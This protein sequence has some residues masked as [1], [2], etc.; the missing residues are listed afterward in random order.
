[1]GEIE[2]LAAKPTSH[3]AEALFVPECAGTELNRQSPEG[4]LVYSQRG[5]PMPNRRKLPFASSTDGSRTHRHSRR[6]ELRRFAGL[7]TVL[8]CPASPM[9]F[10]PTISCVTGRRALRAAPRGRIVMS[11]AQVGLEPTASLVLSQG[12]LPIAYRAILSVSAQNRTRTCKRP[13][14]SR[15]ALPLGVSGPAASDPGWTRTIGRHL[16]RVLPSPLGH[17]TVVV[18][19]CGPTGSRTRIPSLRSWCLPVGP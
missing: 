15:A 16:V 9:G 11:V 5:L 3:R 12:G 1:M 4:R 8:S 19:C 17:G 13:G 14:L 7:R 10:E 6:F 18:A 2:S